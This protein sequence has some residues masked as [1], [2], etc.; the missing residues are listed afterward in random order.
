MS[1]MSHRSAALVCDIQ[2]LPTDARRCPEPTRDTPLSSAERGHALPPAQPVKA[3][4]LVHRRRE[5]S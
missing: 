4:P 5:I 2:H 3:E 1:A